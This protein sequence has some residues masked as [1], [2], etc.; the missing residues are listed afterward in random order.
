[1]SKQRVTEEP[2]LS[3]GVGLTNA[4][5]MACPFCYSLE[6][7]QRRTVAEKSIWLDFFNEFGPRMKSVNFGT[8]ENTLDPF[9]FNLCAHLK[10]TLPS[11]DIA[12]TTN[13]TLSTKIAESSYCRDIAHRCLTDVDVSLDFHDATRHNRFRGNEKAFEMALDTL[14]LCSSWGCNTSIVMLGIESTLEEDN[15][16]GLLELARQ[17]NSILRINL[18]RPV[19]QTDLL[20]PPKLSHILSAFDWLSSNATIVKLSDPLF[21]AV[22]TE[23]TTSSDPSGSTSFRV[24]PDGKVFPSTYLISERHCL[25][26][27]SDLQSLT[28]II[29]QQSW[30]RSNARLPEYC[31]DCA[32]SERCGGGTLD[33]RFLWYGSSS[34]PDPYCPRRENS[35]TQLR[36]YTV[37]GY[38]SSVH[39]D[40]LPTLFFRP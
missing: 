21:A 37:E 8:G 18:Y 4:C 34:K 1:L 26:T 11:L 33:R 16:K 27:I 12:L 6:E 31:M 10:V 38:V 23:A 17:Y 2:S 7:R 36:K 29:D 28:R 9:F 13:G 19:I 24:L 15:L 30:V 35:P 5:N 14:E 3:F 32:V 20:H 25:G 22:L 39:D 40:Y